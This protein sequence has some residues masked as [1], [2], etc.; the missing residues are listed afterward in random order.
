MPCAP[1]RWAPV[2]ART[3]GDVAGL[4]LAPT[5]RGAAL[6]AAT[7]VGVYRSTDGGRTWTL[8]SSGAGVPFA[9]FVAPSLRFAQDQTLFVC[10]GDALY[11][12]SDGGETWQQVLVGS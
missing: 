8:P 9:E 11:R 6:F 12:S 2:A 4:A 5:E 3:D 7:A 1:S 10:A